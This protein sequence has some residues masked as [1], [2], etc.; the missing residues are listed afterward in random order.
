M[1]VYI[2]L[3]NSEKSHANRSLRM[4]KAKFENAGECHRGHPLPLDADLLI[5]W[6]FKPTVC[7]MDA[8]KRGIPYMIVDLGYFN[9]RTSRFSISFNGF[10]GTAFRDPGAVA[11]PVRQRPELKPWRTGGERVLVIGQMPGDQSL[12]GQDIDAWMGRAASQAAEAYGLPVHKRPH[13]KML[14]PW[15]PKPEPLRE[16]L[17]DAAVVIT[18]T[19]TCAIESICEGV[20]TIV[21]HPSSVA[22]PVAGHDIGTEI[23]VTAR[24]DWLHELSWREWDW[25]LDSDLDRLS[26]YVTRLYP[27]LKDAPLDSPRNRI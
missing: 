26:K 13:P 10:H 25:R 14:N 23:P 17:E 20:P 6:G 4:L 11:R 18:W 21:Q 5:Q 7:L 22:Y 1:K 27:Q 9:E 24:E 12:R 2:N 3:R 15:E 8:V 19:S 16:A